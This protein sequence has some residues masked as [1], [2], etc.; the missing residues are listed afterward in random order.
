MKIT[1]NSLLFAAVFLAVQQ[2]VSVSAFD[3]V[4]TGVLRPDSKPQ[5]LTV[6]LNGASDLYLV[7]DFAKDSYDSDQA[8]WAEPTL[9]D[10]DGNAVRL[11]TIKPEEAKTG[12]GTLVTDKNHQ[13]NPL[14][15]NGQKFTF[16]F[17]A[18]APSILHFKLN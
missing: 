10:N 16:G 14:S 3:P 13:G 4:T 15:I 18:H 7:A 9:F 5:K 8:I 12:W 17:W 2:N 1:I 6:N 11:T